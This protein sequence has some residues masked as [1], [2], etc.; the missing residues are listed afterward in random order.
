M[1]GRSVYFGKCRAK[2]N[3]CQSITSVLIRAANWS[4]GKLYKVKYFTS[5]M[6]VLIACWV[7]AWFHSCF[8]TCTHVSV[9]PQSLARKQ[10]FNGTL[11]LPRSSPPNPQKTS[12]FQ[13][14]VYF[15][16]FYKTRVLHSTTNRQN[17]TAIH[18]KPYA[19][20]AEVQK[21]SLQINPIPM[22]RQFQRRF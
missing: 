1:F 14:L 13:I 12:N 22:F 6:I 20:D 17:Q 10:F 7:N 19:N 21:I 2:K 3:E 15:S 8:L 18:E 11:N 9:E 4:S 5:T 16:I